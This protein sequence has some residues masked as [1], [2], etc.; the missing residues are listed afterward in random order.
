MGSNSRVAD[1]SN[2]LRYKVTYYRMLDTIVTARPLFIALQGLSARNK[3]RGFLIPLQL[4][5]KEKVDEKVLRQLKNMLNT[6]GCSTPKGQV[7][8][9][10]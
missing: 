5:T 6:D 8:R 3:T 10:V 9:R 4:E 1:S 7:A 2:S